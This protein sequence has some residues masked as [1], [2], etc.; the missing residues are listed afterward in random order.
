DQPANVVDGNIE[1]VMARLHAVE[2]PLPAAKPI[3]RALAADYVSSRRPGDWAQALM[4]L[5]ASVC[6]PASPRCA[7]CPLSALCAAFARGAPETFP[8]KAAKAARP[9]KHGFA[10][11]LLRGDEI[12]IERRPDKGLLGGMAGLPTTPWRAA[13]WREEEARA[14]APLAGAWKR[15]GAVRH[16]FTHFTLTL[17]I[18]ALDAAR[19]PRGAGEWRAISEA[20]LPTVFRKAVEAARI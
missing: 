8:R 4:D 1:R 12:W 6:T 15:A 3:L 9:Q 18:Y 13:P 20:G 14:L 17:E 5:G 7:L 2:T 11:V 19:T 10:F 16:V